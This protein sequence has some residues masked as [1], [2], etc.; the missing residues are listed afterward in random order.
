MRYVIFVFCDSE[1]L[2]SL[3]LQI[4]GRPQIALS[5]QPSLGKLV[6][7][8]PGRHVFELSA[9]RVPVERFAERNRQPPA[10]PMRMLG[11][12]PLE[13]FEIFNTQPAT[14]N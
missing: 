3:H 2:R 12:Q 1:D 6:Q 9:R 7:Q 10:T 14:L 8:Q 5:D 4:R 13:R 11:N